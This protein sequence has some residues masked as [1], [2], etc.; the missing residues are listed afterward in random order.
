MQDQIIDTAELARRT[1]TGETTWA[2]R[3]M[4]GHPHSPP[5]LKLGR[6]VRYRWSDVEAWLETRQRQSTSEAA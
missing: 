6:S 1:A 5:H 2:K 3:R 4:L